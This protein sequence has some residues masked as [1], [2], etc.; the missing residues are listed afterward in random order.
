MVAQQVALSCIVCFVVIIRNFN[1]IGWALK[2]RWKFDTS[3]V[4]NSKEHP[5]QANNK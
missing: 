3:I 1:G 5:N 2:E 4:S